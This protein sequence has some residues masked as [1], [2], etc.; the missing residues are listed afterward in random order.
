MRHSV[1][2]LIFILAANC[3]AQEGSVP[4]SWVFPDQTLPESK[5]NPLAPFSPGESVIRGERSLGEPS[6]VSVD[7]LCMRHK[8][9]GELG[10]S[11]KAYRSGDLRGSAGHLE[12]VLVI[13]PQ[14][15]PAHDVLGRLFVDLHEYERAR[16]EFEKATAVEPRSAQPLHN[17]SATLFLLKKYPEAESTA[18]ATLEIDPRRGSTRYVLACALVAQEHYTPETVKLLRQSSTQIPTARLILA[19]VLIK[20]GAIDDAEAELHAYLVMPNA[21]GKDEVRRWLALLTQKN[22]NANYPGR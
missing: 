13:C 14:Y 12:K 11:L 16:T 17:L 15:S 10:Q 2:A 3:Y 21:S 4:H 5:L 1:W 20:R 18:R 6:K 9:L 8:A 19:R 7:V 22:D